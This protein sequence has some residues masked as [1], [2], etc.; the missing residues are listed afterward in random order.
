MENDS[1]ESALGDLEECLK[2]RKRLV[3]KDDRRVAETYACPAYPY[4]LRPPTV[5]LLS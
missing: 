4:G 2:L 3:D 5:F 1:M